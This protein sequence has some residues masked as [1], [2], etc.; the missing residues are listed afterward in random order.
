M[1]GAKFRLKS[2]LCLDNEE[3]EMTAIT[4][5][6][7]NP[8]SGALIGNVSTLNF[9]RITSGTTSA[10]KVIDLAF[11]GV[12]EVSNIK[13]G[14]ISN[15]GLIVNTDPTDVQ[16]DGTSSN[17]YFGIETSSSFDVS[18]ASS[19]LSRHFAGKNNTATASNTNNV[20]VANR[21]DT[22]SKYIY[23]DVQIDSS[24]LGQGNGAYKVFFDYS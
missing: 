5:R 1:G 14:L 16:P 15:A 7:Y 10:V 9:G 2:L 6:E 3:D 17:G 20:S 18:K 11:T 13:I 4:V 8:E 21:S 23:L 19:P 24:N 22:I 12:T